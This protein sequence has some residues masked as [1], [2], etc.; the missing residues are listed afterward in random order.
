MN[1]RTNVPTQLISNPAPPKVNP[2]YRPMET[3]ELDQ[4]YTNRATTKE[5]VSQIES[6]FRILEKEIGYTREVLTSV[7]VILQPILR[8]QLTD[9]CQ[10]PPA[11]H[12]KTVP[13]AQRLEELC[14]SVVSIRVRLD[15]LLNEIEL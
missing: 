3:P 7:E 5:D 6:Q 1:N 9:E 2:S 12:Q 4:P 15:N 10:S 8:P 11:A 14:Y 13:L